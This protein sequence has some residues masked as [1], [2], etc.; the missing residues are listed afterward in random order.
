MVLRLSLLSACSD[1][2]IQTTPALSSDF[3]TETEPC[4]SSHSSTQ[5]V[6]S[7]TIDAEIQ[8]TLAPP[9]VDSMSQTDPLVL[10]NVI[11]QEWLS[12]TKHQE[13]LKTLY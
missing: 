4:F 2:E 7:E 8:T 9:M 1:V 11:E 13:I 12:L 10:I 6:L 5:T 3:G